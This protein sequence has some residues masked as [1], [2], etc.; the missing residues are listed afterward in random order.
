[1]A[2]KKI[3]LRTRL[4][5]KA[6]GAGSG[7]SAPPGGIPAPAIPTPSIGIPPPAVSGAPSPFAPPPAPAA[8]AKPAAPTVDPNDTFATVKPSATAPPPAQIAVQI[9]ES[10]IEE[11]KKKVL[12]FVPIAGVAGLVIGLGIGN[13]LGSGSVRKGIETN[14]ISGATLMI[15]DVETS[16][17]KIK[18]LS[19]KILEANKSIKEKKY[20]EN[21]V[22]DLGGINIPFDGSKLVGKGIGYYDSSTQKLLFEYLSKVESLNDRKEGLQRL[23][24]SQKKRIEEA[25]QANDKPKVAHSVVIIKGTGGPMAS[26]VPV[27]D[28]FEFGAKEWPKT[29]K[30]VNPVNRQAMEATRYDSGEPM[31]SDQKK[32]AIPLDPGS[33]S[34]TFPSDVV[35][36]IVSQ[37]IKTGELIN[38]VNAGNED[39]SAG[40]NKVGE[41]LIASLKK[42]AA[43]GGSLGRGPRASRETPPPS[44]APPHRGAHLPR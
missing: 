35:G 16:N 18:E 33:V 2:N 6:G 11:V 39:D 43:K 34:A 4:G 15:K 36:Q 30:F 3:D 25:L 9:D 12:K 20:P 5:N 37:V 29:F 19:D 26:I 14:T 13:V 17:A 7:G 23:F 1:M 38:G 40:L 10:A 32:L 42:L 8:P 27:T 31:F 24:A 44:P 21:F 28:T 22:K 41:A